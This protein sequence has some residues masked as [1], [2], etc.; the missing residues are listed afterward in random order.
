MQ[1]APIC[2]DSVP[3]KM[4]D[5]PAADAVF[6]TIE[7]AGHIDPQYLAVRFPTLSNAFICLFVHIDHQNGKGDVPDFPDKGSSPRGRRMQ[8]PRPCE[9]VGS[10]MGLV[11]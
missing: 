2:A 8:F 11:L 4:K 3:E 5:I 1:Y 10:Q 9:E 7:Q 6:T